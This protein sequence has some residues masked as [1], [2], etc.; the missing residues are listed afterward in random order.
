MRASLFPLLRLPALSLLLAAVGCARPA[1]PALTVFAAEGARPALEQIRRDFEDRSGIR[2]EAM[3]GGGGESLAKMLLARRGDVYLAP[4]QGFMERAA[5]EG[6]IMPETARTVAYLVPVIAVGA[7]NPKNIRS[8]ADLARPGMR[9]AVTNPE[10]TLLGKYAPEMF[11]K[12]GL[13]EAVGRNTVVSASGPGNLIAMICLGQ[14]D[15]G[16][17]WHFYPTLSREKAEAV[18]LPRGEIPGFGEMRAAVSAY[19]NEK[20]AAGEFVE[21]LASD[22]GKIVWK[23][24]G[25][26]ANLKEAEEECR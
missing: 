3:Y 13:A 24:H 12:A 11:E 26:A 7:G 14:V 25:Y 19:S 21:F 8:L 4:E 22:A 1:A 16:I 5:A 23:A 18:L 15:A 2:V 10:T 6:A 20:E 17:A 9:V